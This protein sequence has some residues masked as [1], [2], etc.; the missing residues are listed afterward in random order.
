MA[1][2]RRREYRRE[3]IHNYSWY[4]FQ[5]NEAT[6]AAP[7][8][9]L[10]DATEPRD[11]ET[12]VQR[13]RGIVFQRS[14]GDETAQIIASIVL[15]SGMTTAQPGSVITENNFPDPMDDETD[16]WSLWV[17]TFCGSDQGSPQAT[18]DS[19]SKRIIK[20]D[21]QLY[22]ISRSVFVAGASVNVQFIGRHLLSWRM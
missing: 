17:P 6:P 7:E 5:V 20:K 1:K 14:G 4:P 22:T 12:V 15:P 10:L 2:Y 8:K 11:F 16:D 21:E 18:W 9:V 13:Q 3:K 19:K